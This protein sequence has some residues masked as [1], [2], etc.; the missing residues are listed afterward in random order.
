[1][2]QWWK[3]F[4]ALQRE[5]AAAPYEWE[6]KELRNAFAL[7]VAGSM[8]GLPASPAH[9]TLE[10]LPEMEDDLLIMLDRMGHAQDPW[11]ELFSILE[12]G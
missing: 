3:Q 12:I 6:A 4:V 9:I 8:I 1:M 2:G 10:L 5:R 11:G 7:M